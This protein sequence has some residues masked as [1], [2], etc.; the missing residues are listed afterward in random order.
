MTETARQAVP[1]VS[2][3]YVLPVN[4]RLS[5]AGAAEVRLKAAARAVMN[6]A[7]MM[8]IEKDEAIDRGWY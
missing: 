8:R 2:W 1:S 4:W 3:L 7:F 5:R 6:E